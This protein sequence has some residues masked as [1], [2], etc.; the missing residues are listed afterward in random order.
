MSVI[1]MK[2]LLEVGV[3]FDIKQ[4]MESKNGSIH[5]YIK[6]GIYIIDLQKSSKKIDEAYK[7]MNEIAEKGGKVLFVGTKN[8][9]KKLLKKK[10]SVVDNSGL[11]NVG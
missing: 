6:N 10:L 9:L 4:K 11:T 7:A 2:K 3:H 8:K 1:S 5:F